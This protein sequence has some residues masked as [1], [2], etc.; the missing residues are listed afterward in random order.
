[1]K[2]F[3]KILILE[4]ALIGTAITSCLS[5]HYALCTILDGIMGEFNMN[6]F[7]KSIPLICSCIALVVPIV[8][9]YKDDKDE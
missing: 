9:I 4:I 1:M 7:A 8:L 6:L 3:E 5:D 2:K